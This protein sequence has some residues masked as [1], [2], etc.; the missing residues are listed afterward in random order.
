MKCK[1]KKSWVNVELE[2]TKSRK[3]ARKIAC[4]HVKELGVGYYP[5][6]MKME[7]KLKKLNRRRLK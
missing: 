6:L 5:A 3:V 7:A 4:D 1:V 2:H